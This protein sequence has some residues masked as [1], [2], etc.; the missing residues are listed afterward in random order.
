MIKLR[1]S[2][3]LFLGSASGGE[4]AL[5][6]LG[7][8]LKLA[9]FRPPWNPRQ[10]FRGLVSIPRL[11]RR[12]RRTHRPRRRCRPSGAVV[13]GHLPADAQELCGLQRLMNLCNP[14]ILGKM[15]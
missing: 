3:I 15:T 7:T 8:V 2:E 6:F 13:F 9:R 1:I 12:T 14:R 10:R 11:A 5:H 4:K